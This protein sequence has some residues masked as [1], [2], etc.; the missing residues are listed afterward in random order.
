M[1]L[2]TN[3]WHTRAIMA[4][5]GVP[6]A[7]GELLERPPPGEPAP[8]PKMAPPFIVKPNREDNSQGVRLFR[9]NKDDDLEKFMQ[10]AFQFDSQVICEA[11][12]PL[13]HELRIAVVE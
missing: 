1:A 4:A 3:K 2:S 10:E 7:Y 8:V 12:V 13:G 9:G 5:A 6:V 11:F